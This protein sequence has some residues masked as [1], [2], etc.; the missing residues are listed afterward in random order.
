MNPN[1][2]FD[3]FQLSIEIW[4]LI[5]KWNETGTILEILAKMRFKKSKTAGREK[6]YSGRKY[7]DLMDPL[8]MDIH[9]HTIIQVSA[10]IFF[11]NICYHLL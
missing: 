3:N 11:S 9:T 8:S 4:N 10:I 6:R 7:L 1:Y 2:Y 5:V